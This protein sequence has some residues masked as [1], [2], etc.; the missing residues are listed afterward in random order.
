MRWLAAGYSSKTLVAIPVT[1]K[2]FGNGVSTSL[3]S[4]ELFKCSLALAWQKPY[5]A[6]GQR[7][8][9]HA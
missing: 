8:K 3:F 6:I 5:Y 9:L 2:G 1:K 4:A 7:H